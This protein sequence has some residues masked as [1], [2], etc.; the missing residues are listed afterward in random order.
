VDGEVVTDDPE[1]T[2]RRLRGGALNVDVHDDVDDDGVKD[3]RARNAFV[4]EGKSVVGS[5]G[6]T[7]GFRLVFGSMMSLIAKPR[8]EEENDLVEE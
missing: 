7:G 6:G 1:L 8:R 2:L 3:G 4:K 5:I